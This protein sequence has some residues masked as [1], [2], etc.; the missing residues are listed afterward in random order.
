M[1][2]V[3]MVGEG[4]TLLGMPEVRCY[5]LIDVNSSFAMAIARLAAEFSGVQITTRMFG[6]PSGTT[7]VCS[8]ASVPKRLCVNWC[9]P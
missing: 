3:Q 1:I 6:Q 9:S 5:D 4:Y 7:E 2:C 8:K